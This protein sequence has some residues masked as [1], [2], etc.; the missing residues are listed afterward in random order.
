MWFDKGVVY[1]HDL[2][3]VVLDTASYVSRGAMRG[4]EPFLRIAEDDA[5]DTTEAIDTDLAK[6]IVN[7]KRYGLQGELRR[8]YLD[9]HGALIRVCAYKFL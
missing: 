2:N 3:V 6:T 7:D 8:D 9:Y 5:A 1:G 4:T